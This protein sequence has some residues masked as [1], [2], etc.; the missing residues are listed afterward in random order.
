MY[1]RIVRARATPTSESNVNILLVPNPGSDTKGKVRSH[2]Y[3]G[4]YPIFYVTT[5]N[6]VLCPRCVGENLDEC[7]DPDSHMLVTTHAAN[8]NDADLSCN[9]CSRRIESAYGEEAA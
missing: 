3:V 7:C 2:S 8:W 5:D 6:E 4:G 1:R 9:E